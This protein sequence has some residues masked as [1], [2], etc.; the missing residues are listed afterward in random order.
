MGSNPN[1]APRW[2]DLGEVLDL[3]GSHSCNN[4]T[5]RAPLQLSEMS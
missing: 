2:L 1:S 5:L 4:W 3:S